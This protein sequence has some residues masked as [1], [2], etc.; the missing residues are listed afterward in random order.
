MNVPY[1]SYKIRKILISSAFY[2]LVSV[3]LFVPFQAFSASSNKKMVDFDKSMKR[4]YAFSKR[5]SVSDPQWILLRNLY[6]QFQERAKKPGKKY[7]I[8]KKIHFIWLGSPLPDRCKLCIASWKKMHP[9]WRIRVWTDADVESFQ[10]TNK[11]HF[12][13]AKNWGEKSDIWRYEI[14]YRHGGVYADTDFECVKPFDFVHKSCDLYAG[15]AY[16]TIPLLY[17]GLIGSAP[18]HPILKL[19]ID[20]MSRSSNN[21]DSNRIM[22]ETGPQ[23]FTR[24]FFRHASS[25]SEGLVG[26]PTT[27]LYPLP[28]SKRHGITP[29]QAKKR[30]LTRDSLAIHYWATSWVVHPPRKP[31]YK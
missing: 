17:N 23:F 25:H 1:N 16:V 15:T 10:M 2:F 29:R 26:L 12:D 11:H 4:N 24:C 6:K 5:Q 19:C 7:R 28:N 30:W 14:L 9:S 20:T 27:V 21:N 18:G 13:D 8:P 31:P 22:D 3:L